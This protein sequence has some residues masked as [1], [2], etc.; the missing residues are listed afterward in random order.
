VDAAAKTDTAAHDFII[1]IDLEIVESFVHSSKQ[2]KQ[3][4][5][6]SQQHTEHTAA[7]RRAAAS[8]NNDEKEGL[9]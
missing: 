7:G 2:Q 9:A 5:T 4:P 3:Q 8:F 1:L 6:K